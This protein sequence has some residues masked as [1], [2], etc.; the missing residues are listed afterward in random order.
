MWS[1]EEII[2]KYQDTSGTSFA[3][4]FPK[5]HSTKNWME[6]LNVDTFSHCQWLNT[7]NNKKII[8][9]EFESTRL[10]TSSIAVKK[11]GIL[12]TWTSAK[13]DLHNC[14]RRCQ[15]MLT[16]QIERDI[17]KV[18]KQK[19]HWS[20]KFYQ[21]F[22]KNCMDQA[23]LLHNTTKCIFPEFIYVLQIPQ[24]YLF[25]NWPSISCF[26]YKVE[27]VLHQ[28]YLHVTTAKKMSQRWIR[29]AENYVL[30]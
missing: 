17:W 10:I 26:W 22:W 7:N 6:K 21:P 24:Q 12:Q 8:E 23:N 16:I 4:L 14:C 1:C 2:H 29:K 11:N 20:T 30:S 28:A 5:F 3:L 15:A 13:F 27:T 25:D 18:W 19:E 9:L